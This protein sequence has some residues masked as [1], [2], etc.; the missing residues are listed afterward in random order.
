MDTDLSSGS[1]T[2]SL[3][4]ALAQKLSLLTTGTFCF[5]RSWGYGLIKEVTD[6]GR[7]IIDFSS[8]SGHT[9][10]AQYA[11]ESLAALS[12][13]HIYVQK[14]TDLENLKK[15]IATDP[16]SVARTCILSLGDK[17]TA[18]AIAE[19]LSPSVI[20]A[21]AYKKWWDSCK[22]ALKKDGHFYIPSRKTE[23]LRVLDAPAA[24][25]EQSLEA[26]RNAVGPKAILA[27]LD[28]LRKYWSELKNDALADE[29]L[30]AI[31]QTISKIPRTQ[32]ASAIELAIARDEFLAEVGRPKEQGPLSVVTLTPKTA[33]EFSEILEELPGLKQVK[34][35]KSLKSDLGEYWS[36][37]YVGILSRA[38]GR[39]TEAIVEAFVEDGRADEIFVAVNRLLR[40]RS[41]TCDFMF[42]FCKSRLDIFKDLFEPHLIMAI[43]SVLEADQFSDYKK[44]TKLY[45]LVLSDKELISAILKAAPFE[46][47]RDVT[48][49]I[50]LS[51]VF[52]ELDKRSLLATI[53]KLFPE[54]QS[55]IIGGEKTTEDAALIVS[56]DSLTRR[57]AELE[58][59]VNK[60]IPE[61]SK[62]IG[63][64]RSYG[65]LRENHEFKAA[66]E[67]QTVLMR[68]KAE[69]EQMLTRAQGTDFANVDTKEVNIGTKVTFVDNE[70]K[71]VST[72]T[73]LGA[74]D[75]DVQQGIISYLTP[76][77]KAL[78]KREVGEV[79]TLPTETSGERKVTIQKIEAYKK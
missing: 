52:E 63:I 1:A 11:A 59:I 24:L 41:I 38:N 76:V 57:K 33:D 31:N 48:R 32:Q 34:L 51:P 29:V 64:A 17:A 2:D 47:V 75:S 30:A 42:W 77:A 3:S 69:L 67:M 66:K 22:R 35:M 78:F 62:E 10:Q 68:R 50:L 15:R 56:W 46:D 65:D 58:E 12:S 61:N 27:A 39:V 14:A 20:P 18:Q 54:V 71:A 6:D 36:E 5:H 74:W 53:V 72:Y 44:G 60:K 16:V 55:M 23:A 7:L 25:G 49:A 40:E 19:E 79:I 37:L 9:M 4:P 13:D 45:E 73:I 26:F 43:L 28:T 21:S 8:K 70:S